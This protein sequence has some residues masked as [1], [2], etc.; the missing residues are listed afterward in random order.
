MPIF[1]PFDLIV[2]LR[3]VH[4]LSLYHYNERGVENPPPDPVVDFFPFV[5]APR[6]TWQEFLLT[7]SLW[8][9]LFAEVKPVDEAKLPK[10]IQKLLAL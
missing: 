7:P 10:L 3:Q 4:Y 9:K 5:G 8:C 2:G 6:F 1:F